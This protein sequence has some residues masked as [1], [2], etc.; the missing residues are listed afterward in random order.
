MSFKLL[1]T[2][3]K[4]SISALVHAKLFIK[5]PDYLDTQYQIHRDVLLYGTAAVHIDGTGRIK[6][7]TDEFMADVQEEVKKAGNLS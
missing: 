7:V 5:N 1:E 2:L 6:R 4:D 3:N